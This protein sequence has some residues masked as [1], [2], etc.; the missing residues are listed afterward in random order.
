[1]T[2]PKA[3]RRRR[4]ATVPAG[5]VL[6]AAALL[7]GCAQPGGADAPMDVSAG[8]FIYFADAAVFEPCT[9]G[10]LP[11]AQEAAYIDLE[12]AYLEAAPG[13]AEPV[14]AR[15]DGRVEV[16]PSMEG[17]DRPHLIVDR[18]VQVSAGDCP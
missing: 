14:L 17:P 7:S 18:V 10:R 1:M 8:R 16:R 3:P 4:A 13:P 11:V 15:L 6:A 12:R 2:A 5:L 9:G